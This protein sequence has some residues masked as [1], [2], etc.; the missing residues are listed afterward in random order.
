MSL[1]FLLDDILAQRLYF[2]FGAGLKL[3]E[4]LPHALQDT[5]ISRF[6]KAHQARPKTSQILHPIHAFATSAAPPSLRFPTCVHSRNLIKSRV[7][8][9]NLLR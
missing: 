6:L 8:E 9:C 5:H 7:R 4:F 2:E 1:L 3:I